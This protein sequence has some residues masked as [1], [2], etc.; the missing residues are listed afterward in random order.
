MPAGPSGQPCAR[1]W[2]SPSDAMPLTLDLAVFE[3]RLSEI[4][5][6]AIADAS[7]AVLSDISGTTISDT[8]CAGCGWR[9]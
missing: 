5:Q 8:R 7:A 6:V 3:Q 4:P 1:R 9:F 2:R